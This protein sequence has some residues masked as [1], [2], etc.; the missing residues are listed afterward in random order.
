LNNVFDSFVKDIDDDVR[1][2]ILD[3]NALTSELTEY[4]NDNLVSICEGAHS[5]SSLANVKK[6]IVELFCDKQSKRDDYSNWE[7]GAV[8]ELFIHLY[9]KSIGIKQDCMFLNLEERSIKKGFDGCYSD[10]SDQ[11]IM[12]SKSGSIK[13][14]GITHRAKLNEAIRDLESK[15]SGCGTKNNPW[16]E[17]YNHASHADVKSAD[18]VR[19]YMKK[20]A[21]DFTDNKVHSIC[22]FNIIPCATIYYE[23]QSFDTK[24]TILSTIENILDDKTLKKSHLI[25]VSN[26]SV[27]VFKKYIG[28]A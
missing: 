24:A 18:N 16:R 14:T 3:I 6:R 5:T 7:M 17:A 11:W 26:R 8:A 4:I 22:E 12:E 19:N 27:G 2:T 9:M 10:D 20:L 21:E 28:M 25:C 1:V 13:T 23:D 15:F